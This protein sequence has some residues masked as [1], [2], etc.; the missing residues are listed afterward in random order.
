MKI[1]PPSP[2]GSRSDSRLSSCLPRHLPRPLLPARRASLRR[3]RRRPPRAAP[4][5]VAR[6]AHPA[7]RRRRCALPRPG[8]HGAARCADRHPPRHDRRRRRRHA[9][10]SQR[11][12]AS[13]A[14]R[15]D[16]HAVRRRAGRAR[17]HR[18]NRRPLPLLARRA[19]VRISRRSSPRRARRRSNISPQLTWQG[20]AERYP[21]GMPDK[22]RGL[23]EH[24]LEL[25]AELHYEAYFL[26]VWDL[27]R[28]ARSR[29][30]L[31]QGRGSAAN[32]AVCFCLGVTSR[33]SRPAST[34]CSSGS[35]AR[36]G[37]K[38]P[39]STSTSSTSAARKCCNTLRQIRP[40]A[41]RP[42][43]RGHHLPHAA[44]PSATSA[45][46]S[47][48]R[49]TASTRWPSTSKA[50]RTSRSS[51]A[52]AA[53]SASIPTSDARP[54]A[55][56]LRERAPRLP[57][58]PVAARRRHGD[59]ARAAVRAGADRKRRHGR[60][61]RHRVGQGRPRRAGHPQGRLPVPGHAHGDPQMLR[62]RRASTTAA[63]SRWP[64]SRRKTRPSTT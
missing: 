39:T 11:R 53:K 31:C 59:H 22:V 26:T 12:A 36:S 52:A 14:A 5:T 58:A 1:F 17:P 61:H 49:S 21:D 16:P 64:R 47:A 3:R 37:T 27:V 15:R 62:P 30:I 40:R 45:R 7:R 4:A 20:A 57:A 13:A 38:R 35:S 23:I 60:P 44:R 2:P 46:R 41:G 8:A 18:R 19:A 42:D 10:V 6:H 33:R 24:E 32:S 48:C 56:L 29:N 50:T 34:C 55:H 54:A 51:S 25:I 43:R 28:F 9:A 63:S